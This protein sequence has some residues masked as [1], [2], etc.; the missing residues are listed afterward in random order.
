M[1]YTEEQLLI[2]LADMAHT[3]IIPEIVA[4][5]YGNGCGQAQ[6]LYDEA[7]RKHLSTGFSEEN[8]VKTMKSLNNFYEGNSLGDCKV[9]SPCTPTPGACKK[10]EDIKPMRY[11]KNEAAVAVAMV[12]GVDSDLSKARER[13]ASRIE[14]LYDIKSAA[15][16]V[17][18]FIDSDEAPRSLDEALQR[19]ADGKVIKWDADKQ[20]K[21]ASSWCGYAWSDMLEWRS[22][23]ADQAGFDKAKDA[24]RAAREDALDIILTQ[25]EKAGFEALQSFK[26]WTFSA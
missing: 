6:G 9:A 19:I 21:K 26:T 22:Q 24:L 12:K 10:Q 23:P 1:T 16:R 3:G 18:F 20:K 7:R 17:T 5:L 15:L 14:T 4:R 25:D 13:F 8:C 2:K 11:E